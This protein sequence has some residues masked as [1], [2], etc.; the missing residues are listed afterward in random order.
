MPLLVVEQRLVDG[1]RL[2]DE[3]HEGVD[4]LGGSD[5]DGLERSQI[6]GGPDHRP[7]T[8][9]IGLIHG[10]REP[11][12]LDCPCGPRRIARSSA[13]GG[14]F[15]CGGDRRGPVPP[16]AALRQAPA[17]K[18]LSP[19]TALAGPVAPGKTGPEGW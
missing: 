12:P 19:K 5:A 17:A 18:G 11:S 1:G 3:A 16:D 14:G 10:C 6:R 4:D 7:R 9:A 2:A 13:R 15:V 8:T